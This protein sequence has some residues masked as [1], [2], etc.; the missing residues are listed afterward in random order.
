MGKVGVAR[1]GFSSQAKRKFIAMLG[2]S[3]QLQVNTNL[4]ENSATGLQ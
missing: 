1:F 4:G 3:P 2:E